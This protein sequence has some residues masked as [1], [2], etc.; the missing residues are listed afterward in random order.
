MSSRNRSRDYDDADDPISR[1]DFIHVG[2][3]MA[4]RQG[5]SRQAKKRRSS[6]AQSKEAA[7]AAEWRPSV[8]FVSSRGRRAER[9]A[10][11]P[12]DFMD[13]QDLADLDSNSG[14]RA[15]VSEEAGEEEVGRPLGGLDRRASRAAGWHGADYG[16][17][18]ASFSESGAGA[19]V[20][21]RTLAT[22]FRRGGL[23]KPSKAAPARTAAADK[24]RSKSKKKRNVLSFSAAFDDDDDEPDIDDDDGATRTQH[25]SRSR[26]SASSGG[27]L[28]PT[29]NDSR[30]PS[31]LEALASSSRIRPEPGPVAKHRVFGMFV[32]SG[33]LDSEAAAGRANTHGGPSVP[34]GFTGQHRPLQSR[35]DAVPAAGSQSQLHRHTDPQ[36]KDKSEGALLVTA[37]D[38]AKLRIVDDGFERGGGSSSGHA[39][40]DTNCSQDSSSPSSSYSALAGRQNTNGC[41]AREASGK[42]ALTAHPSTTMLSRFVK[43]SQPDSGEGEARPSGAAA[44]NGP[45]ASSGS[46]ARRTKP[47]RTVADWAPSL[48]LCKRMGVQ[49]PSTA[50]KAAPAPHA[51]QQSRS[52]RKRAADFIEWNQHPDDIGSAAGP[53]MDVVA[54]AVVSEQK[55]AVVAER[56]DMSLFEAIFG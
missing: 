32:L 6:G 47:E 7:E 15:M 18:T 40:P 38:R 36:S 23:S 37:A 48:L 11:R 25:T 21:P 50:A 44:S 9:L 51:A 29:P 22:L 4:Q 35:W 39:E 1:S 19:D 42:T 26:S 49:P 12:E 34:A 16:V 20:L 17:D 2:T 28:L 52:A 30:T 14:G 8:P 41:G 45:P 55:A 27:M 3:E 5:H 13:A 33:L 24:S 53:P 46:S 10:L 43:A 31:A 54:A 56:P